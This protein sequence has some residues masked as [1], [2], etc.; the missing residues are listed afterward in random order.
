MKF[1][2]EMDSM[3]Y[4]DMK[5]FGKRLARIRKSRGLTQA[6]LGEK[7]G[8][9]LRVISYYECESS[10]PPGPILVDLAKA[11]DVTVDELMGSK[12]LKE[13]SDPKTARLR[14]RLMKVEKL[15]PTDQRAVLKYIDM[16]A[17]R[18]QVAS[19]APK[20]VNA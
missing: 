9:S 2:R 18:N 14:K 15:P 11:L 12:Q 3:Q 4:K 13:K 17:E 6:E 7:V 19:K 5:N 1:S 16:L 20:N 10:Q 8:V